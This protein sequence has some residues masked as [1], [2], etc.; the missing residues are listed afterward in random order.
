MRVAP[1]VI[2]LGARQ[3]GK[4]TLLRSLPLLAKR[5]YLTLDDFDLRTQA[6]ADPEAVVARAPALVL[7]EVQRA[8]D[9]LIAVK[10][11]VDQDKTRRPGRFLLT[12]SANL[13]LMERIGETLAGR[14]VYVTLWPFTRRERLGLGRAGAWSGLLAARFAS[15]REIL[16]E[17]TGPREDWRAAAR[18]G[19]FPVPA[20]ELADDVARSLWFSGYVQTYLERDLQAVRAVENLADFRRLMRAACLRIGALLNQ[21]ELGRDVGIS[22]PQVHR[23]MNLM[24]TSYQAIRLP[25]YSVSRTRRLIKAPKLYWS[26]TALALHLAGETEPRGAHLENLVLTDLLAWRDVQARRPEILYWR[27]AAGEEV[28]FVIET[29][30]RLLPIEVKAGTRTAPSDAKGL[31]VFLDEYGDRADGGL[32]LY[33]G[34]EIFP[35]TRRVLAAPWWVVC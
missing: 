1:V 7:D 29:P 15:W 18:L 24:E 30:K 26:D 9:L 28:D 27:T 25:A 5:P 17:Q 31:E 8:R 2:L 12:G 34:S 35:L 3:T 4:T 14:A 6:E 10:R 11:A 19:G 22:Q 23:F 32:L 20:H 21:T 16:S 13:L 33:G